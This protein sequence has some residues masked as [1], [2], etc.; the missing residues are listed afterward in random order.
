MDDAVTHNSAHAARGL[1]VYDH[2]S[3]PLDRRR[4]HL[5]CRAFCIDFAG[6]T[7]TII[8][9]LMHQ[10][11][12]TATATATAASPV[13]A[14]HA[15]RARGEE[16]GVNLAPRA[17]DEHCRGVSLAQLRFQEGSVLDSLNSVST[18]TSG[19]MKVRSCEDRSP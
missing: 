11:T 1:F 13:F 5:P 10:L 8:S 12:T 16:V 19:Y 6:S 2:R 17:R 4:K 3:L 14:V 18:R 9:Q 7:L 15:L